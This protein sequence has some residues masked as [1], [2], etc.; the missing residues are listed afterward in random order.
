M[1]AEDLDGLEDDPDALRAQ[2]EAER[3][4]PN[5]WVKRNIESIETT[6]R[7]GLPGVKLVLWVIVV[8][9]ALILWRLWR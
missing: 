4:D 3:K 7:Y 8:L 9:L 6:L 2:Q 5:Y 1:T